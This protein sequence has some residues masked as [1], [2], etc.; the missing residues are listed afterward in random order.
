[1]KKDSLLF[2]VCAPSGAGKTTLCKEIIKSL[3]DLIFSVSC[4]TRA[5]RTC[6]I[7]GKD[8][9]FVRKEQFLEMRDAGEFAEWSVVF[10]NYY[11]TK[12]SF[13]ERA[14]TE[15]KDIVFDIDVNGA[16]Q[17]KAVYPD[18]IG[19]FITPPSFNELEN[20][21]KKRGT[22]SFDKI[23]R[24]LQIATEELMEMEKFEYIVINGDFDRAVAD[25]KSIIKS[26]RCRKEY[27][28]PMVK[29]SLF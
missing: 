19:I 15:G 5:P 8:Y 1:M 22:E 7:E 18:G 23:K 4:T 12:F 27:I 28:L 3:P 6:E 2:I 16:K 29:E 9:F 10:D 14:K 17:L 20:R 25:F 26:Q 11:G 13:I 24:R 21:L